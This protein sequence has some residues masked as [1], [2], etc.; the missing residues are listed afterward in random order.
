MYASR[1]NKPIK[2]EEKKIIMALIVQMA[3]NKVLKTT[4]L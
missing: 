4:E 1:R 2:M 3:L